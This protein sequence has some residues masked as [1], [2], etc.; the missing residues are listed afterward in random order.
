M[1]I[2]ETALTAS[3]VEAAYAVPEGSFKYCAREVVGV[4]ASEQNLE[5]AVDE[6]LRRGIDRS[7]ISVLAARAQIGGAVSALEEDPDVPHGAFASSSSRAELETAAVGLPILVAGVGSFAAILSSGGTLALAMT[8]LLLAGAAGESV[9]G[10]FAHTISRRH[11]ESIARQLAAGGLVIWVAVRGASQEHASLEALARL[12]AR[13][14]HVHDVERAWGV[15]D[16]AE[17]VPLNA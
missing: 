5:A 1:T 13:D 16:L 14:L 17:A 9:G 3:A 7:Q 8:A 4:L 15:R 6:L 10:L 12:G 2:H 11:R